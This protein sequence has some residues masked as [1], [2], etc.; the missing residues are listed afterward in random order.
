MQGQARA[1]LQGVAAPRHAPINNTIGRLPHQNHLNITELEERKIRV[2]HIWGR[3]V[4]LVRLVPS[5]VES[6]YWKHK[7]LLAFFKVTSGSDVIT[8]TIPTPSSATFASVPIRG[9]YLSLTSM[10]RFGI[11][12]NTMTK[13]VCLPDWSLQCG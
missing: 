10:R 5:E 8:L 13:R 2:H 9:I 11:T 12:V 4:L 6:D 3:H 7:K 1:S